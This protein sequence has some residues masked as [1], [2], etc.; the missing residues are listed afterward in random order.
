MNASLPSRDRIAREASS[1]LLAA[2]GGLGR[3]Q[4]LVGFDGFI[5]VIIRVVDRRRTMAYDDF[6][7]IRTIGAFA[8]RL[9]RAAGRSA[10]V[11]FVTSEKRFGGNG[12]LLAGALGRMGLSTTYIGAVGRDDEPTRLHP[13][14]EPFAERCRQVLPIA[15]PSVTEACEFDDGKLMFGHAHNSTLVT[16]SRVLEVVG[17]D[18]VRALVESAS[19]I[20]IV[21]WTMLGG[22]EGIWQGLI[23]SVF[24]HVTPRRRRVFIDLSDPAKRTD[25]DLGRGLGLVSSLNQFADVT[26][27]LNLAESQRIANVLGV[28]APES[29]EGAGHHESVCHAAE[30]IRGAMGIDTVVIHRRDGAAGAR[31]TESAVWF[32]GPF[33]RNP[34]LSTG[35]GDHFNAGFATAQVLNLEISQCLAVACATSGLYVR[36]AVSPSVRRVASFLEALP[37]PEH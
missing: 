36:E 4:A 10:N 24:P 15:P 11:E 34:Q 29:V 37:S 26:L 9:A 2:A 33:T 16:W 1:A 25:T 18:R 8:E 27:G 17:L 12:P 21:N 6:E 20:S 32:D 23:T 19:L 5:D 28:D 35:A 7:S 3:H 31:A 13:L 30:A 14:F 22:V